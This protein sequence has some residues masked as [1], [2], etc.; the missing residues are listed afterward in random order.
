M[1]IS[2]SI[3]QAI[4]LITSAEYFRINHGL[5]YDLMINA[6]GDLASIVENE[7]YVHDVTAASIVDGRYIELVYGD[8]DEIANVYL[9]T[10]TPVTNLAV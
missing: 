8:D 4:E 3:K 5:S 2:I 6:S 1:N 9:F 10:L 7:D